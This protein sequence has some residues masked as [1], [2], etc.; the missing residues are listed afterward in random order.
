MTGAVDAASYPDNEGAAEVP[1]GWRD[2]Y[3]DHPQRMKR[4]IGAWRARRIQ[5]EGGKTGRSEGFF[6]GGEPCMHV[7]PWFWQCATHEVVSP[8]HGDVPSNPKPFPPSPL[9][10][11]PS[12]RAPTC[13]GLYCQ[14]TANAAPCGRRSDTMRTFF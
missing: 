3:L 7:E 13:R 4:A 12:G 9:P 6:I 1:S 8:T 5:Q 2:V 14:V 10:V 11:D